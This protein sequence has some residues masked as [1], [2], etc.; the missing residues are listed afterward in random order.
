MSTH[1][2]QQ[3][4]QKQDVDFACSLEE[5]GRFRIHAFHQAQGCAAAIRQIGRHIPTLEQLCAPAVLINGL[6]KTGLLLITGATGS[7]KSTTLAALV[8]HLNSHEARHIITL[9]DPIEFSHASDK[10]LITQREVS[11]LPDNFGLALRS[12]LRQDPDVILIGEM[13]DH[14]TI[15]LAL[16]AAETG[17]LVLATL[18]TR[19][20][21][22]SVERIVDVFEGSEKN[23][24]RTQLSEAL[25]GVVSQTL[26]LTPQGNARCAV[27]ESLVATPAVRHLIK[28]CKTSQL[29]TLMQ[30][31]AALGMQTMQQAL[32]QAIQLGRVAKPAVT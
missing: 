9:E 26:H 15:R 10:S 31:G 29:P 24:I 27:F 6:Q 30:T 20:A 17:H 23:L 7:G 25:I 22:A 16:T 18:H 14:D 21:A 11:Y 2:V 3:F 4:H 5:C 32:D 28:E 13:R 19:S 8:Q 1:L 12:A